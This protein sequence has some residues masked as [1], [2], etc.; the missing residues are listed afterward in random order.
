M[1]GFSGSGSDLEVDISAGVEKLLGKQSQ[2]QVLEESLVQQAEHDMWRELEIG[3]DDNPDYQSWGY[4][5]GGIVR[6]QGEKK[7]HTNERRK[8]IQMKGGNWHEGRTAAMKT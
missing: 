4:G 8:F 6:G 3:T 1:A 2:N 7:I 5:R